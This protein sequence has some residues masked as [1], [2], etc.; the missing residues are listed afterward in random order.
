MK[1][2]LAITAVL[3]KRGERSPMKV[4]AKFKLWASNEV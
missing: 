2:K 3:Q 4:S 1:E